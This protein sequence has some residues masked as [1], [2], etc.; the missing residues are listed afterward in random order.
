MSSLGKVTLVHGRDEETLLLFLGLFV[1][2]L[3][4]GGIFGENS[5]GVICVKFW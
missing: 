2:E 5:L 4:D 1:E 3:Q